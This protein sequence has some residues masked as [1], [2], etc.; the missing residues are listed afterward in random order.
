MKNDK[1]LGSMLRALPD[2]WKS[3]GAKRLGRTALKQW[4]GKRGI[5]H[6]LTKSMRKDGILRNLNDLRKFKMGRIIGNIV[7]SVWEVFPDRE[8]V[9]DGDTR[10]TYRD[11]QDRVFHLANA[12][13]QAGI[14]PK[15]RVA[16]MLNNSAE[17]LEVFMANCLIGA[18]TPMLN[19]HLQG[20]EL[21]DTINLSKPRFLIYEKDFAAQIEAVRDGLEGPPQLVAV[22]AEKPGDGIMIYEDL[23]RN[24]VA[25]PPDIGFIIGFNPYTGGTTGLPKSVN[26]YDSFSYLVSDLAERPRIPFATYLESNLT[27]HGYLGW[28]GAGD[29]EDPIGKNIRSIVPTPMYHAGTFAAWSHIILFASTIVPMRKF[30]PAEFLKLIEKER[31]S[32]TFVAPTILQRVLALPDEIKRK[33]NLSSMRAIICAAAPCPPDVKRAT[34]ELFIQQGAKGPVFHEYYG[35]S[36][37]AMITMLIPEDYMEK[38]DRYRSVGKPRVGELAIYIDDE[39]RWA[40]PGEVG[41]VLLQSVS[42]S[43]LRYEGAQEKLKDSIRIIDDAEWFD[44]GLLGY[45]DEDGFLYLTG[46][47]KEMIISGGVNIYP[48]E[49]EN[50]LLKHRAVMDTA[51]IRY[52]D[53]GLGEVPLAA[54]QLHEG[55]K[56][57]SEDIIAFCK[58]EGLYGFKLPAKVEFFEELPRHIDGKLLKREIEKLY[59]KEIQAR[60]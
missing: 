31:I 48:L 13:Q 2:I 10:L 60:G 33:Y 20:K 4:E 37:S 3:E 34:N 38:P 54:I 32:W 29:I 27:S 14:K 15:D 36:E 23:M 24:S 44:D 50:V 26:L 47:E 7:V 11:F 6:I 8:A 21:Q 1:S 41:M 5:I 45:Q 42:T 57:T 59:W 58:E 46:R 53:E 52:P 40:K 19:W 39:K 16:V 55:A 28:F 9:V 25:T 30:D 12:F 22:G 56:A 18:I 43:S 49:I 17:F 35:S 51:V